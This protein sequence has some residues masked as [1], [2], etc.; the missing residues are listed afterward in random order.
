VASILRTRVENRAGRYDVRPAAFY[1][2]VEPG[3]AADALLRRLEAAV[4]LEQEDRGGQDA[5]VQ[6]EL[7]V[8]RRPGGDLAF[9]RFYWSLQRDDPTS[10]TGFR[11]TTVYC[12]AKDTTPR[13]F[14]FPDDPVLTGLAAADGPLHTQGDAARVQV[15]RYIPLRRLTFRVR[16]GEDLPESAVAKVKRAGSGFLMSAEALRAVGAA[17]ADRRSGDLRVP[18]LLRLDG[19]RQVLYLEDLPGEPLDVAFRGLGP[20]A[21]MERLGALHRDL[22]ELD[23]RGLRPHRGVADWVQDVRRA[24]DQIGIFVGSSAGVARDLVTRLERDT[25]EEAAPRYCQGDFV[26]G[27]VLCDPGG[28]SVIDLDDSRWADPLSEVAG[29]YVA[30]PR[31]LGLSPGP[32][33]QARRTYLEA[34]AR[35]S[36]ERFDAAR[37][38]WFVRVVELCELAKRLVKGRAFP[39]E[40]AAALE[41]LATSVPEAPG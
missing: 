9:R 31:D 28:W 18:R 13:V 3:S 2:A 10:P 38:T 19:S 22:H 27:Q 23:V 35:R 1:P 17:V 30:L 8:L 20:T 6:T 21:A 41:R 40:T 25:P 37:W 11:A 39:G 4:D 26:P 12:D 24:A 5:T 7:R 32:A 16:G 14:S 33:E 34:Y 15:L 29:L 36:G